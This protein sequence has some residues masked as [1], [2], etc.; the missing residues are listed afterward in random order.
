M[1]KESIRALAE[2][3]QR[4]FLPGFGYFGSSEDFSLVCNI[5]DSIDRIRIRIDSNQ[6]E[7]LNI[8]RIVIYRE[9]GK[10][11]PR[12]QISSFSI[13]PA[14]GHETN[15]AQFERFISGKMLHSARSIRPALDIQLKSPENIA[16]IEI[17][18]RQ[19]PLAV[20]ARHLHMVCDRRSESV[21]QYRNV[22]DSRLISMLNELMKFAG[23]NIGDIELLPLLDIKVR[24][25]KAVE[26][27]ACEWSVRRLVQLLPMFEPERCPS[28]YDLIICAEIVRKLRGSSTTLST[29]RLK[30]LSS[31]LQSDSRILR[32]EDTLNRNVGNAEVGR[33]KWVISKHQVHMSKL[34]SNSAH[35]LDGL[36][37]LLPILDKLNINPM[38]CY[39]TLLGAVRN[40]E[41]LNHD[42]DVDI[43]YFDG[44]SS[45]VE[46]LERKVGIIKCLEEQGIYSSTRPQWNFHPKIGHVSL[47]LF[48]SWREGDY[49]HLMMEK[50]KFR[51]IPLSIMLPRS[52]VHLLGC[53][54]PAPA[55]PE[56][57]LAERYGDNWKYPDPYHEWH[58]PIVRVK[59]PLPQTRAAFGQ[60]NNEWRKQLKR[61]CFVGWGQ[62]VGR[63]HNQPPKNSVPMIVRAAE[64]GFDAVELD[65]RMSADNIPVLSHD[66]R[67]RGAGGEIVVSRSKAEEIEKF[68]VG[69]YD[70]E[71]IFGSTFEK[72]LSFIEHMDVLI[73]PRIS[74][75]KLI[76]LKGCI[77]RAG[78]D[79][80]RFLF[81]VYSLKA[82]EV[83]VQLFPRS[84][85]LWKSH[86]A[87]NEVSDELLNE[88]S[89][90]GLDG[91]M[92][93][94]PSVDAKY[95]EAMRKLKQN[96]LRCL[97]FILKGGTNY[98][99]DGPEQQL[100]KMVEYGV[101]YVTTYLDDLPTFKALVR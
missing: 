87:V 46:A 23:L 64:C 44:S 89:E 24:V 12:D 21:Y 47:D 93:R 16:R 74:P 100:Q 70:G 35:Y 91:V 53:E 84:V 37:K 78:I 17:L 8:G 51:S 95:A 14:Y 40:Q 22:T 72:A 97:L 76:H 90:M 15:N 77:E 92:L 13:Y 55:D 28:D 52:N 4:S 9:D 101:D 98:D 80:S 33:P 82:A 30:D 20:R 11:C 83:L 26:S 5:N 69:L 6:P 10:E 18:N 29:K 39:G 38:I 50:G 56:A 1:K 86:V 61:I 65:V 60:R 36:R 31:I 54:V 88:V 62:R 73:D 75:E 94:V 63:Q 3:W 49:L 48:P 41:F 57:F 71:A 34:K 2:K 43:L 32:L 42:D 58:W 79:E 7:F 66:A 19:G 68:Q 67:L 59:S 85:L 99:L 45:K 27:G 25:A 81:C 96:N